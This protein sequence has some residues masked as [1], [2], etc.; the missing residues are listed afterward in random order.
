MQRVLTLYSTSIGKKAVMALTGIVLW[1]FVIVHMIGNLKIY[2]GPEKFDAYAHFLREFGK[3][4]LGH[5]Q[6]LWIARIV[7]LVAVGAHIVAALQTWAMSRSA[8]EV[9][10]NRN[11][12]QSFSFASSTMRW[13]GVTLLAFIV[14][15][16]LH[17]TTGTV[18]P[19]FTDSAHAN[20]IAGF[21]VWYVSAFYVLAMV[22]LGFHMYHGLW[23]AC[24]TLDINNPRIRELRRPFSAAVA[25]VVIAG[26]ISIPIAV[27]TGLVG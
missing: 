7:L 24:Q 25:F 20:V 6:F 23:S 4:M 15:H 16:L 14:F 12:S 2:Q 18:H 3:P 1:G 26:N 17:L 21:R 11:Q 27:L 22:P 10:Y 13:G 5:G 8:R 9:G 19:D